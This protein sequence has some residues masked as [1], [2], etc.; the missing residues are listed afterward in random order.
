MNRSWGA[1]PSR[2]VLVI[3]AAA[4]SW[5]ALNGEAFAATG[6]AAQGR[7]P[8]ASATTRFTAADIADVALRYVGRSGAALCAGGDQCKE[9]VN[10]AV[11]VASGGSVQLGGGYASDYARFGTR[12]SKEEARKGDVIQLNVAT[13]PDS[14]VLGMH[15]AVVVTSWN[16]SSFDVVDANWA[17]P[18]TANGRTVWVNDGLVQRHPWNPFATAA[19]YG[20]TVSI[21]RLGPVALATP[22]TPNAASPSRAPAAVTPTATYRTTANLNGRSGPGTSYRILMTVPVGTTVSV[23]CQAR[24]AVVNGSTVWDRISLGGTLVYIADAYVTTPAFNDFTVGLGRC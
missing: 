12:V 10:C 18:V 23:L 14:Y 16:S 19:T 17:H 8:V 11:R 9:F 21:W 22:P 20:L 15:S 3:M 6:G 13:A 1:S 5:F 4:L 7:S 2:M 24:G